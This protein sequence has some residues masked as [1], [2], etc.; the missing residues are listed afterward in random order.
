MAK[1]STYSDVKSNVDSCCTESM[2]PAALVDVED[3]NTIVMISEAV[4]L[5]ANEDK[6]VMLLSMVGI[7]ALLNGKISVDASLRASEEVT[8]VESAVSLLLELLNSRDPVIVLNVMIDVSVDTSEGNTSVLVENTGSSTT[9]D[10][11]LLK[12]VPRIL[13]SEAK[14]TAIDAP[15]AEAGM[16]VDSGSLAIF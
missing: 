12:A 2:V 8:M 6:I 13:V 4:S 3:T 1:V 10:G 11:I 14:L 7:V 5:I 16:S 9:A 15:L